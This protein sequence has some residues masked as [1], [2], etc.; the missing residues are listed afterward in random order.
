MVGYEQIA[1]G[2]VSGLIY[3]GV[4]Y[5]KNIKKEP[6]DVKKLGITCVIGAVV[7]VAL[8]MQGALD[9]NIFIAGFEAI[10]GT[11]LVDNII[12]A[13]DRKTPVGTAVRGM[14]PKK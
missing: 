14:L 6:L 8:S 4:A 11:V 2:M 5:L 12:K 1:L 9:E 3:G 13:I 10:G 7:G